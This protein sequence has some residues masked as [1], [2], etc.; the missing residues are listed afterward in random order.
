LRNLHAWC[1][2]RVNV[3]ERIST[4]AV[5]VRR[6]LVPPPPSPFEGK[7]GVTMKR[8]IAFAIVGGIMLD[9]VG[10]SA[11]EE[12]ETVPEVQVKTEG[13]AAAQKRGCSLYE[14]D[15]YVC[16]SCPG[17]PVYRCDAK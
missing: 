5:Q 1:A 2:W 14:D 10:C 3:F 11:V 9:L 6:L 7:R 17:D 13:I 4:T 16:V 8:W 15:H 12:G